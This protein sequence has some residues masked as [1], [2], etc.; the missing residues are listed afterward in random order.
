MGNLSLAA[1]PHAAATEKKR[2]HRDSTG[3]A[4]GIPSRAN[5]H[6]IPNSLFIMDLLMPRFCLTMANF[7]HD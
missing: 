1:R 4:A 6:L 3:I 5:I 7:L 2:S